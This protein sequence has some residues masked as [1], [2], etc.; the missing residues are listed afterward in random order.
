MRRWPRRRRR[1]GADLLRVL[2]L[3]LA[4]ALLVTGLSHR[5]RSEYTRY[6]SHAAAAYRVPQALIEAIIQE[7]SGG[8]PWAVSPVGAV[9]L[10][11]VTPDKFRA[12]QDPFSPEVN[13]DVGT[14]YLAAMLHEFH[15]NV[16]LALAAYNAGPY[17]VLR[18]HGVPPYP[19]TIAYVAEVLRTY[20]RLAA[21]GGNAGSDPP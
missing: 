1:G 18:H 17:A 15:A 12:G 11:Q 7:E 6:V 9:G 4:A 5:R 14:R 3:G 19:Q 20:H 10:M 21:P 2:A 13:I 16:R 8:N